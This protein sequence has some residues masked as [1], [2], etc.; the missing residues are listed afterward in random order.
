[1]IEQVVARHKQRS[2]FRLADYA[3]VA[4]P[5][6][7]LNVQALTLAHRR[8]P[9]IEEFILKCL[10][11]NISTVEEMAEFLG[12]KLEVIKSALVNLAQTESVALTAARGKQAWTL[13]SKG[14]T[15]L[16]T[17]EL[18]S[19]E[20]QTFSI[21]FDIITRKPSLYRFQ[22]PLKHRELIENGL[23]E[24][25]IT[26]RKHPQPGEITPLG[27]EKILKTT[28]G[29]T[30]QRRDVLAI[31]SLENIK[32][33]YIRAV[34]LVYR[35][36][37]GHDVQIGFVIDGKL[38]EE[39]ELAFASTDACRHLGASLSIDPA[40]RVE[41]EAAAAAARQWAPSPD[42]AR[43][44]QD[45]TDGAEADFAEA[46]HLLEAAE[47][48]QERVQ[49]WERL[50]A[51]EKEVQRLQDEA[52][53]M[54]VRNLYV[55]DHP[56]L[57]EDALRTAKSRLMIISPWIKR[58]V[59]DQSFVKNVD[60]LL[61]KGVKVYIGYGIKEQ[62]TVNAPSQDTAAVDDLKKLSE[63]YPT[64]VFTRLGNTHAKVLIKDS[65]FAAVTSFN[66]LS[67]K[68]DP[69]RT[70]RDEQG[71]LLQVPE[72]VNGK[73]AELEPRF[74]AANAMAPPTP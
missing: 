1:M 18:V 5:I 73:F 27:I 53:R 43:R 40:E 3:E 71:T 45:S 22:K 19:P 42:A 48:S 10:A 35:S 7:R 55:A 4:I 33:F 29:L 67:F 38:S 39:H 15:T 49:L 70:F 69:H 34:A 20:E 8:L 60:Q 32:P 23:K 62:P 54:Q 25:E 65:E 64:F 6:Y 26:P 56:P 46:A 9:P 57:L 14:R 37:E 21:Q 52:K 36:I 2:G 44:L 11:L 41:L 30:D 66:W 24:I 59:V 51:A 17:A 16:Q 28:P 13:T 72:L 74:V 63:K 50:Q 47:N 68:G 31:R 58:K 12:L 61:S